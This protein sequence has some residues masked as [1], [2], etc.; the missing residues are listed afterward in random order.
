MPACSAAAQT[1]R[2]AVVLLV[3][4]AAA[5]PL[6]ALTLEQAVG[7]CRETVGRPIVQA[8]LGERGT[9]GAFESCRRNATPKV[10]ACVRDTIVG[11]KGRSI[12]QSALERCRETVGRPVV[13]ACMR[14]SG[15]S[16]DLDACRGKAA[17]KVRACVRDGMIAAYGRPNFL[18]TIQ[19]CRQSIGQ[20]MVQTCMI[21]VGKGSDLE[22]CQAQATP[23]VQACVQKAMGSA[24]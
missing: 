13:Q 4:S 12:F 1:C 21:G 10:R 17:P 8:C 11:A 15:P 6:A 18:Q 14:Q 3:V 9:S 24:R 20:P 5:E 16:R 23:E 19:H 7:H 2:L 22:A